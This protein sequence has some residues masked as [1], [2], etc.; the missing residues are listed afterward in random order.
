MATTTKPHAPDKRRMLLEGEINLLSLDT[1]QYEEEDLKELNELLEVPRLTL[2]KFDLRQ[3]QNELKE[4]RMLASIEGFVM[5]LAN[6]TRFAE[7]AV[8]AIQ[9]LGRHAAHHYETNF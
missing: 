6:M 7:I 1:E 2:A 8:G 3:V 5:A 9:E 4:T